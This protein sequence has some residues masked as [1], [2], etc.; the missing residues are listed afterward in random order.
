MHRDPPPTEAAARALAHAWQRAYAAAATPPAWSAV[1]PRLAPR[2]GAGRHAADAWAAWCRWHRE[3]DAA[4]LPAPARPWYR[5][6]ERARVETLAAAQLCGMR[7]NLAD[8]AA[9][10][11]AEALRAALYQAARQVFA[12]QAP[13]AAG[14][15]AAAPSPAAPGRWPLRRWWRR[16]AAQAAAPLDDAALLGTLQAARATLRDGRG[17]A[18]AV[19][20]LALALADV[21]AVA[22]AA[23]APCGGDA[24]GAPA[25]TPPHGAPGAP[26]SPPPWPAAGPARPVE[27]AYPGYAVH[28]RRWDEEGPARRWWQPQDALALRQLDGP[29]RQLVRRFAHRLQR[30]LQAARLRHWDFEQE[31]GALDNRRLA[32]L[33]GPGLEPARVFR[34]EAQAPAPEACVTLLVDQSASMRGERRLMAALAID[35][36][37]HTL[38]ACGVRCEVLGYTTTGAQDNPVARHWAAAGAPAAPGRLNALR[39]IVYKRAHEPWRLARAGLGL[40]LREGFGHENIDGEALHWAASRLARQPQPR[41]V[42]VVLCDGT[43]CDA[44]TGQ[45]N[46]PGYLERHLRAVIAQVEAAGIRLVALGTGQAVGRFYRQAL[47]LRH[48]DEVAPLLFE[49]LADVLAPRAAGPGR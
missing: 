16:G 17:F 20:A 23:V 29:Q 19:R 2:E 5:V 48:P 22:E 40:L 34:I 25:A 3:A 10:Q 43:P 49:R 36:A 41:K 13:P 31:H 21:A 30:R 4:A 18:A 47:T 46:G 33:L 7:H 42:L 39:H 44:A 9:L 37:V 26:P 8:L 38:Q 35:L 11:P 28:S 14:V 45:A 12:G 24:A 32:Q 1:D 27:Q 6:L 15:L